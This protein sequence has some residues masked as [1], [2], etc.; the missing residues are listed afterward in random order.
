MSVVWAVIVSV[1]VILSIY[2]IVSSKLRQRRAKRITQQY[3]PEIADHIKAN[4]LYRVVLTSGTVF[5]GVRFVGISR[6][7]D[8][9]NRYLPYPLQHWLVLEVK[10]K[11]R[12]FIRPNT[13]KYYEEL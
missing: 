7:E 6:T 12:L 13:V 11:K 1:I 10:D 4:S 3:L 8:S 2:G 9:L 5:D